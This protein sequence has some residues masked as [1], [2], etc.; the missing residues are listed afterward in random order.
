ML[1][2]EAVMLLGWPI[3]KVDLPAWATDELLLSM[4]GNG[5]SLP[6]LLAVLLS[7]L[8]SATW[9]HTAL[10]S[11]PEDGCDGGLSESSATDVQD[12]LSLLAVISRET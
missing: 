6:V 5:T 1:G 8:A 3:S 9:T 2:R 11:K 4:A 7:A 12:A 10:V